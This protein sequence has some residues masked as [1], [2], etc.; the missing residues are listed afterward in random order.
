LKLARFVPV[1]VLSGLILTACGIGGSGVTAGKTVAL[2]LPPAAR[3]DAN[4]RPSFEAKMN[5][6]CSDCQ[7]L[8]SSAKLGAAQQTQAEA[9][10]AKGASVIVLDPVDA[11]VGAAIVSLAKAA[12]IPVISYDGLIVNTADVNYYLSFD[13]AAVGTL[14]GTALLTAMGSKTKPTI[15]ELNGDAPD[16]KAELFR[17][18]AHIVLDG[19]VTFGR[20]YVTPGWKASNAKTEM[21]QAL[22]ALNRKID[23]VLAANDAIADGAIA[24]MKSAGLKPLPPVTG[25][26]ADLAAIQRI[27][28]G[29]QYMT[30]Y[31][32]I[33][34]EAETAAQLAY[35]LAFGVAVPASLTNGKTVN[36][37]K[38]DIP[39]VLL[40]PVV[41]T[42]SNIE[43][44]V[45]A[46]GFW[47]ADDICTSQ[48]ISACATAG[49]S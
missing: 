27:L 21:Q 47:T 6:L 13:T 38:A 20:E 39:S 9:A 4:D 45:V 11:V 18:G 31:E 1:L 30:V 29:D 17:Q 48:Y 12:N 26:G 35:D 43:S 34:A 46:D 41:V 23:G 32:A 7:V 10:I 42:K 15:V 25:Q 8:Y 28:T 3:Y 14:Q 2:L 16:S 24:A 49:I 19:K 37:G 22:T 44:T 5:Q 33:S 40:P 36:N